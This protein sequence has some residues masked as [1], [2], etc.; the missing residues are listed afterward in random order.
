M[1]DR[2]LDLTRIPSQVIAE[3]ELEFL[4]DD[5]YIV[6]EGIFLYQ[7]EVDAYKTAS[8]S[9]YNIFKEELAS[10]IEKRDF[11]FLQLP[12]EMIDLII[13]SHQ[14][15]HM[16]LIGRFDFSGGINGL[17]IKLL[18]YNADM[19]TLL[20]ETMI[21]QPG[22]VPIMGGQPYSEMHRRLEVAFSWLTSSTG[23]GGPPMMLG[24]SLGHKEDVAN[25]DILL[26]IA[27][28]EGF[29]TFYADLPE[30]EFAQNEG[31]FL[32][33]EDGRYIQFDYFLKL[34]PWE[35]IC[36][37]EPGLLADLHNLLLR[38]LIKVLNPAYSMVF[39][40][41]G[42]MVRLYEKYPSDFLLKTSFN[43]AD[44]KYKQY[45]KKADFGRLGESI[46]VHSTS[47]RLIEKSEGNL[48]L[49]NCIYQEFA[50]LYKDADDEYYQPGI[51]TVNG[52][53]AGLSF[54]RAEKLIVDNDC[55]FIPHMIKK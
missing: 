31:V 36:F 46:S 14:N 23:D 15:K 13:H 19:P 38:D 41:K 12:S 29:E 40:S 51:Y 10:I 53:S 32:E 28:A 11:D 26:S 1:E 21:I 17:P 43:E 20:P 55:Q 9:V 48:D 45:V 33:T 4:L 50:Q 54:R 18:E 22:F 47:G 3:N 27:Q 24:S 34:I 39:Q 52:R 49:S 16:H 6:P 25:M 30:V 7:N 37:D 5:E 8:D 42:F 44:M 35:F 2:L